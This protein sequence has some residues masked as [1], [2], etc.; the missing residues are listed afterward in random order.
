MLPNNAAARF[1]ITLSRSSAFAACFFFRLPFGCSATGFAFDAAF[2]CSCFGGIE[3]IL[4]VAALG[5]TLCC[6]LSTLRFLNPASQCGFCSWRPDCEKAKAA[7]LNLSHTCILASVGFVRILSFLLLRVPCKT[8]PQPS[9]PANLPSAQQ[10][11]QVI[12]T[13][14]QLPH[15]VPRHH[16]PPQPRRFPPP[17]S[18][19]CPSA[20]PSV[21]HRPGAAP[22]PPPP[23]PL[24]PRIIITHP[25]AHA[26][27]K[28]L[29]QAA[30]QSAGNS[31]L[32]LTKRTCSGSVRRASIPRPLGLP[33][34]A[35]LFPLVFPLVF[36]PSLP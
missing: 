23:V 3:S 34:L 15:S 29:E 35:S 32:S 20:A 16:P 6:S 4:G 26:P 19:S 12:P 24:Q 10:H 17:A 30:A 27:S 9:D 22:S 36:P 1:D 7:R 28:H 5:A 8:N 18:A 13:H 21:T 14:L 11:A 33:D 25:S 2:C 31:A